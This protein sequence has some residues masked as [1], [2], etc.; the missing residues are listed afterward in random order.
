M[1]TLSHRIAVVSGASS[2]IG[3]AIALGL[4]EEGARLRLIGRQSTAL[5]AVAE[6]ARSQCPEVLTYQTEL[7]DDAEVEQL[8]KYLQRDCDGIDMLVHSAGIISRGPL[9]TASVS[10]LDRQFRTNVRAPYLLTQTLLPMLLTQRGQIVFI[11]SSMGL[12]TQANLSQYAATKHALKAIADSLRAEVNAHGLR[13]LSVYPGRTATPQ[14]SVIHQAEGRPYAPHLLM[15][16]EDIATI[17]IHALKTAR[18]ADV[19]DIIMR[20]FH[21][22]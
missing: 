17:V 12:T 19:T 14:Q 7:T 9:A 6:C 3:K 20:P 8:K 4:A 5:E 13:V 11:N 10:E 18:T 15:Q 21:K 1:S 2:G 22:T 16:P